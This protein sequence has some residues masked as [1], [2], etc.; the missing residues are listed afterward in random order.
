MV[1]NVQEAYRTLNILG[2][3]KK[4][5]SLHNKQNSKCKGQKTN[6]PTKKRILKAVIKKRPSNI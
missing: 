3:K 6:K 1:I 2:K 5:L 4:I